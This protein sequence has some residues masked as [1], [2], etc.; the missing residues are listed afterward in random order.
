MDKD[1]NIIG[2]MAETW[3]VSEDGLTY[4]FHLREA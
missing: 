2:G 1:N 3:D 4:T